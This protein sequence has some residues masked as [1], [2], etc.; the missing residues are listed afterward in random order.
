MRMAI[1]KVQKVP[2]QRQA[3]YPHL[4]RKAAAISSA[5]GANPW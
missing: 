1:G 3:F 4:Y 2:Q 5:A